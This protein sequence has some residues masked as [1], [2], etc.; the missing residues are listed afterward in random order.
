MHARMSKTTVPKQITPKE[1]LDLLAPPKPKKGK[2]SPSNGNGKM[3]VGHQN[4]NGHAGE[5]VDVRQLLKVLNEVKNG[6]F[7]VR[8]PQDEV[9]LAGKV[10]DVLNDIIAL[11]EEMM[12]EFS[13]AGNTIGKKGKLS[14]R[15]E[16]PSTHGAWRDGVNSL[17]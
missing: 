13:R 5:V 3:K 8:M 11:N 6:N 2:K 14:Q 16:V 15:I 4:G 10:C 17:N 9:G 1:G 7:S 12:I